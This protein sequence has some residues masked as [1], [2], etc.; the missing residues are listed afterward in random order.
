MHA[1][2]RPEMLH[3]KMPFVW[4]M[5]LWPFVFLTKVSLTICSS[6]SSICHRSTADSPPPGEIQKLP[7]PR[8]PSPSVLSSKGITCAHQNR[9]W[10]VI[11]HSVHNN[12]VKKK[13]Q[14]LYHGVWMC[15]VCIGQDYL[16]LFQHCPH[17]HS[18]GIEKN[19]GWSFN[20]EEEV[21]DLLWVLAFFLP[22]SDCTQLQEKWIP[23]S[24]QL[25]SPSSSRPASLRR[26]PGLDL[27]QFYKTLRLQP[28]LSPL[29]SPDSIFP[30]SSK[31]RP[32]NDE[33]GGGNPTTLMSS[34]R[35]SAWPGSL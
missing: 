7:P 17:L 8:P 33:G 19:R 21:T 4:K 18:L 22:S 30:V 10:R 6:T 24:S 23:P 27:I 26:P 11:K 16:I 29:V 9:W 35:S 31:F 25:L 3:P 15:L 20:D 34:F 13:Q 2:V 28:L 14:L 5:Q 12:N 1:F 32:Q